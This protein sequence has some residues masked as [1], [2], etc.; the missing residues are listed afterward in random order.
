MSTAL[1]LVYDVFSY[2]FHSK[3]TFQVGWFVLFG[4]RSTDY[5]KPSFNDIHYGLKLVLNGPIYGARRRPVYEVN[6][7]FC[8]GIQTCAGK[9]EESGVNFPQIGLMIFIR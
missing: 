3:T 7:I 5:G 2:L 1:I 8:A 6:D 4:R 9:I